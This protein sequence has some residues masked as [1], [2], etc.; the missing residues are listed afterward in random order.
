MRGSRAGLIISRFLLVAGVVLL[1]IPAGIAIDAKLYE[2]HARDRMNELPP[3]EPKSAGP[4]AEGELIGWMEV[5]RLG[6]SAPISEG[7]EKRTLL[8]S[9]GHIEGTP[10]PGPDGNAGLAGHR[11]IHFRKLEEIGAGD[12]VRVT[13]RQGKFEYLVD[14]TMVVKPDRVDLLDESAS[15]ALTLVTCYPFRYMGTA[16]KRFVVRA[17]MKDATESTARTALAAPAPLLTRGG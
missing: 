12:L 4:P 9:V 17:T 7:T 8:R 1:A 5:P 15:P 6:L 11:D 14:T 2:R 13:T 3:D 16:P 10:L